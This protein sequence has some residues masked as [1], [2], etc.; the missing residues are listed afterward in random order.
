MALGA[1]AQTPIRG[2]RLSSGMLCDGVEFGLCR[3]DVE[4]SCLHFRAERGH[5]FRSPAWPVA[6][7]VMLTGVMLLLWVCFGAGALVVTI[8]SQCSA[9]AGLMMLPLIILAGIR[10]LNNANRPRRSSQSLQSR[11]AAGLPVTG[12][13]ICSPRCLLPLCANCSARVLPWGRWWPW[14]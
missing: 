8:P 5:W 14:A 7:V 9:G 1:P 13:P 2:K 12:A 3:L 10:M 6:H 11:W 4:S